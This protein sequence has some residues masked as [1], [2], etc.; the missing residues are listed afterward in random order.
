MRIALAGA[1]GFAYIL[2]QELSKS[3]NAVLVLSRQVE[4]SGAARSFQTNAYVGAPGVRRE[5]A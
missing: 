5:Y 4:F 1:G 2:A 3:A